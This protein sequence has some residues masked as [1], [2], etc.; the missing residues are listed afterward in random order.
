LHRDGIE[1]HAFVIYQALTSCLDASDILVFVG[2][3]LP[4]LQL[5]FHPQLLPW[6]STIAYLL[7]GSARKVKTANGTV[8]E[9]KSMG[10]DG[11][12]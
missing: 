10:T 9:S 2:L 1:P 8:L 12:K 11:E 6:H 4:S 5:P 7:Y 3:L